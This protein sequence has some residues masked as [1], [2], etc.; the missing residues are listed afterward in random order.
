MESEPKRQ[1]G[2][3][4][5]TLETPEPAKRSLEVIRAEVLEVV[6]REVYDKF[7]TKKAGRCDVPEKLRREL[8]GAY[9]REKHPEVKLAS[10]KAVEELQAN[11]MA[12]IAKQEEIEAAQKAFRELMNA[13]KELRNKQNQTFRT[14]LTTS[15]QVYTDLFDDLER[16][17]KENN[18]RVKT[19]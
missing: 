8:E 2:E 5:E 19:G 3:V 7:K 9:I 10:T 12:Q 11:Q 13:E 15:E 6:R 16:E 1:K 4:P 17:R 14:L 18:K